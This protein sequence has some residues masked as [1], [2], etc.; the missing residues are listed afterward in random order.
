MSVTTSGQVL[1]ERTLA[2]AGLRLERL[3]KPLHRHQEKLGQLILEDQRKK[4][5]DEF[6]FVQVGACDGVS[7]DFLY[8]FV[9]AHQ[10]RG[11]AVEPLP[12]LYRELKV[13]YAA[14]PSVLPLNV[15]LHRT[16]KEMKMYRISSEAKDLPS[17][18]KG[19]ASM[20]PEHHKLYNVPSEHVITETVPCISWEEFVSQ[21][22]ITRIDY[23]QLDTEG[24]DYEILEMLDFTRLRPAVIK[25]EH[26][27]PTRHMNAKLLANCISRFIEHDYHV[28]TMPHDAI[29]YSRL[30]AP[31]AATASEGSV[32]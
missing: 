15:G 22:R 31:P 26:D 11:I 2:R 7:F 21:N 14:H 30:S 12:D 9:V 32:V 25:F 17:W 23:L 28:L 8:D 3:E 13:N 10:L 27:V 5:G 29:A 6:F 19:I 20:D 4:A 18:V 24:Y 16:A 1:V